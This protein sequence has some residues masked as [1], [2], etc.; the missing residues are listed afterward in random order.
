MAK[1]GEPVGPAPTVEHDTGFFHQRNPKV[2]SP[3]GNDRRV[4]SS[5]RRVTERREGGE[6]VVEQQ[7]QTKGIAE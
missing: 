7:E 2:P 1:V 6:E 3:R 5:D 4:G